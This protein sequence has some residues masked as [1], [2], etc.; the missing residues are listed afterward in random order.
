MVDART[1]WFPWRHLAG[2][3]PFAVQQLSGKR[4]ISVCGVCQ[5]EWL[6]EKD[7][8]KP[9]QDPNKQ[10]QSRAFLD[11]LKVILGF[12]VGILASPLSKVI[13]LPICSY[14]ENVDFEL[15]RR[16]KL[17]FKERKAQRQRAGCLMPHDSRP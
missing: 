5:F 17:R 14:A 16:G 11:S 10:N 1:G 13:K 8:V 7:I 15:W 2:A 6:L 9:L 3:L 12:S 4:L